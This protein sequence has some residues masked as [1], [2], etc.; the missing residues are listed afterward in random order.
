MSFIC[1]KEQSK[2]DLHFF[3]LLQLRKYE[4]AIQLCEQSLYVAEKNFSKA[5][6]DNQLASID[7]SGCYSIAMLWRWHLMS[8]SYFYMG[9]LEKALDLLQKLEQVGSMKDK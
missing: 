7:G 9:K 4:E 5:E 6:I 3:G 8:K 1:H 2:F